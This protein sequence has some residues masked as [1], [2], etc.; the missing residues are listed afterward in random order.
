MTDSRDSTPAQPKLPG[1]RRFDERRFFDRMDYI[2]FRL[3][4]LALAL[5]GMYSVLKAH[6]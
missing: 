5:V 2:A 4:L 6:L 3:F 1:R